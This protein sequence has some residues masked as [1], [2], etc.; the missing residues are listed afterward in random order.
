[1]DEQMITQEK[2]EAMQSPFAK[3]QGILKL[4]DTEIDCYVSDTGQRLISMR[5]TVKAIADVES[6]KLGDYIGSEAL[7]PYLNKDFILGELVE[8]N[9]PGTQLKAKCLESGEFLSICKAFV[10]ALS[11]RSLA[12]DRQMDIAIKCS[13]L[14]SACAHIGLEALIDEATGYQ[15]ERREDE[16]RIKLRLYIAEELRE[17]EK[18]FP[19]ELWE[20]FGRLTGWKT[21]LSKRPKW[22]GKLVIELIYDT[23]DPD[24]AKYLRENKPPAGV[25]WH[26]QMTEHK[27][28]HALV[29]R[30]YEIIGMAK[31]CNSIH[32]LRE[33]VDF[34]YKGGNMQLRLPESLYEKEHKSDFNKNLETALDYSG[35]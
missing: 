31:S 28:V 18:T 13:A 26:R 9:L 30:C 27:G 35:D 15:Y 6:G 7:K 33:K 14:L 10:S 20:E 12:T 22:W 25:H 5:A 16:L 24:V 17:W 21:P 23:L 3:Y 2:Q 19:D 32:E 1:M 29:S 11:A 4:G 34:H 8:L